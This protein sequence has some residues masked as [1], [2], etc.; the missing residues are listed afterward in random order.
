[1]KVMMRLVVAS[2][3]AAILA[4]TVAA[5]PEKVKESPK[6]K[7]PQSAGSASGTLEF[8]GSSIPIRYAV[9][10][11]RPADGQA[12]GFDFLV[13][14]SEG[15]VAAEVIAGA[16]SLDSVSADGPKGMTGLVALLRE[17]L[18]PWV[19]IRHPTVVGQLGVTAPFSRTTTTTDRI[20]GKLIGET[21]RKGKPVKFDVTFDAPV[22]KRLPK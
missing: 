10:V 11:T 14:L 12:G 6:Q 19:Q 16:T 13:L 9:A 3:V 22:V 21:S 18:D 8:S 17:G 4:V 2:F 7:K 5:T 20:A 15:P 1:V